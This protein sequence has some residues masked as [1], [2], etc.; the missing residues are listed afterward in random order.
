MGGL[1]GGVLEAGWRWASIH[2]QGDGYARLGIEVLKCRQVVT[3]KMLVRRSARWAGRLGRLE[4]PGGGDIVITRVA[5][6]CVNTL[7]I[8]HAD[9]AHKTRFY[10]AKLSP[11]SL[12]SLLGWHP[13]VSTP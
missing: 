12:I 13:T 1:L 7:M 5:P 4:V 9:A 2:P 10:R 3:R 11:L 6:H 8:L